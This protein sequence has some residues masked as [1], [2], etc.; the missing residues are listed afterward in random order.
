MTARWR[1]LF[2]L[3]PARPR[4]RLDEG[5]VLEVARRALIDHPCIAEPGTPLVVAAVETGGDDIMWRVS[6]P[7]KGASVSLAVSDGTGRAF[8]MRRNGSR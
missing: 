4:T 2:G 3:A 5:R 6:T 8:D 1:N 7:T